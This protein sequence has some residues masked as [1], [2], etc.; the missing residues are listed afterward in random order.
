ML[1]RSSLRRHRGAERLGGR[2]L[3]EQ[4]LRL[5]VVES[6]LYDETKH[7]KVTEVF[8]WRSHSMTLPTTKCIGA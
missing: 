5:E 1:E 7:E 4:P 8:Y 6:S 3:V 2:G